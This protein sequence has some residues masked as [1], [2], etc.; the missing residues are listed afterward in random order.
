MIDY[1]RI[2]A[3]VEE[4][5]SLKYEYIE[6]PWLV[7]KASVD[8]TKPSEARYFETPFGQL[9]GSGEQSFIEIRNKLKPYGRYQCVTPCFRDEKV[10]ELHKQFF[11]KLELITVIAKGQDEQCLLKEMIDDAWCFFLSYVSVD[12]MEIVDKNDGSFDIEVKGIEI[13]SYGIRRIEDF[14]WVYGTGIAE[15]RFSQAAP[16][17]DTLYGDGSHCWK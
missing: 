12:D 3:A 5:H 4:Y 10:D 9:V 8:V 11:I 17:D 16:S 14:V 1:S 15:P 7:S 6:V 13:G 2:A